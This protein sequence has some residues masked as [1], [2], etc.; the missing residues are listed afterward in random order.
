MVIC[1][2]W[3][4]VGFFFRGHISCLCV[5][6]GS[7]PILCCS[8]WSIFQFVFP[9]LNRLQSPPETLWLVMYVMKKYFLS[10][11]KRWVISNPVVKP[12]CQQHINSL[13]LNTYNQREGS[14]HSGPPD[15]PSAHPLQWHCALCRGTD[16]RLYTWH[17]W[18]WGMTHEH[19]SSPL[20][21]HPDSKWEQ[22]MAWFRKKNK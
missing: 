5:L 18:E 6:P 15:L 17:T 7:G 1:K 11:L 19:H 12:L 16:R 22:K 2:F 3:D 14:T 13:D 9:H 21:F 20:H 4:F 8:S 10:P